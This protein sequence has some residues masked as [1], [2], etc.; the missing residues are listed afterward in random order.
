MMLGTTIV[1]GMTT[2]M[3]ISMPP[4]MAA[5][6]AMAIVGIRGGESEAASGDEGLAGRLKK[7]SIF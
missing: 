5:M 7:N 6:G 4:A 3:I 2:V 1:V